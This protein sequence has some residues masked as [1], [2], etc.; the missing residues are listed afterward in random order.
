[1]GG[2]LALLNHLLTVTCPPISPIPPHLYLTLMLPWVETKS[3]WQEVL[4]LYL[5][6]KA[7][8]HSLS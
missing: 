8:A 1:M 2:S 3:Y 5:L 6:Q 7:W 4:F